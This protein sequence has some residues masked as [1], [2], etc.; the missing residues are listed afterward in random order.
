MLLKNSYILTFVSN[1]RPGIVAF[2]AKVLYERGFN[3]K[4]SSSTRL[5]EIFSMNLLVE[6]E[7]DFDAKTIQSW[8]SQ[9]PPVV[10]KISGVKASVEAGEEHF[11]VSVYGA[12]KPGIVFTIADVLAQEGINIVDLQTRISGVYVMVLEISLPMDYPDAWIQKVKD[13]AKSIK[14]DIS[15]RKLEIFEL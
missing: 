7:E 5:S 4:D 13:A 9:L 10:H 2:V 8:F 3:I 14:T 6:H 12:D 15:V 1:D 11:M